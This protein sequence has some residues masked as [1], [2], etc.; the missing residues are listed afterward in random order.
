MKE[1][2]DILLVQQN[3]VSSREKAKAL[4]ASGNVCIEGKV[5][6]KPSALYEQGIKIDVKENDTLKYV[7]RGGFK[8]EKAL[9]VFPISLQ[10]KICMDIGASTGGF[11]DCM[12]QNG[13]M[14]VY[15]VDVG[16]NQLHESLRKDARVVPMEKT[17][18][19]YLTKEEVSHEIL[20]AS[21]DVSFI[22]LTKI[23]IAVKNLLHEEGE[24]VCLIKPQFEAGKDKL[25][26]KGVV[27]DKNA[28][29]AVLKEVLSYAI[30]CGFIVAGIDYSPIKGPEGNIEYLV[31]LKMNPSASHEVHSIENGDSNY[32]NE[33]SIELHIQKIVGQAHQAL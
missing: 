16:T 19:R 23:L 11:T 25:N 2:L 10:G 14:K 13:A 15:A 8:L 5:V 28:H 30:N 17:N 1:R 26:K 7:S 3:I 21:V 9:E 6:S 20:F 4:I 33:N 27:K 32:M 18:I 31:Y 22:S 24:V 12:L 29:K